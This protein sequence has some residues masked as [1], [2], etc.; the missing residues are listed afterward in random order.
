MEDD[1]SPLA[2]K[3]ATGVPGL[4]ELLH[5]GLPAH[6][7]YL[8]HGGPGTGKTTI[9]LHFLIEG[10][11]AGERDLYLTLAQGER[12]LRRIA[13]AH[14]WSLEGVEVHEANATQAAAGALA[15]QT[16]FHA[17]DLELGELMSDIL[18][19]IARV[20]PQRVVIDTISVLRI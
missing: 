6:E 11:R 2:E 4:D 13:D 18:A 3:A 20:R 14:G 19:A 10:V 9:A 8:L 12:A 7:T 17:S 15:E 5:G 1:R 16:V